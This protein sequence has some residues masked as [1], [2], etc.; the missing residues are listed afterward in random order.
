MRV[1]DPLGV[2]G[3]A[4]RVAERRSRALVDLGPREVARA[5]LLEQL[6]VGDR[7][8]EGVEVAVAHHHEVAHAVELGRQL[9]QRR[10]ERAV[11]ED[12]PVLRVVDDVDDLLGEQ[13]DVE[14][15]QDGAV[16]G[17][18]EVELVVALGVP[19]E[20]RHP[21]AALDAEALEHAPEAVDALGHLRVGGAHGP[22]ALER[23]HLLV[24]I[25]AAQPAAHGPDGEL[26]VVLHQA[27][28]HGASVITRAASC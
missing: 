19:G 1:E 22:L 15:V 24:G 17:H 7:A 12:H 27:L 8:R 2:A 6:L 5:G 26:E 23:H 10:D 11:D 25:A 3:G 14:R 21:V 28:E 20:G 18:G 13:A 16:G 9:R 4:A